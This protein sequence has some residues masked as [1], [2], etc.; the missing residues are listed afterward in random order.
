MTWASWGAGFSEG[1]WNAIAAPERPSAARERETSLM[2][3]PGLR[4]CAA[5]QEET[6]TRRTVEQPVLFRGPSTLTGRHS[7]PCS[8]AGRMRWCRA[9]PECKARLS[10]REL[11]IERQQQ[12]RAIAAPARAVHAG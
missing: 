6:G 1:C 9:E 10:R 2:I 12:L 7:R 4:P 3:V 8:P 11:A 5:T